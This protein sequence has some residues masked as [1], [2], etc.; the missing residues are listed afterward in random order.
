MRA[1]L[2]AKPP[3]YFAISDIDPRGRLTIPVKVRKY[4]DMGGV[5]VALW[6]KLPNG[7]M[8]IHFARIK[9]DDEEN[10]PTIGVD[11]AP[12]RDRTST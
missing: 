11:L 8:I 2:P 7:N 12:D 1:K 3:G 5:E 6:K 4:V 10:P 9:L